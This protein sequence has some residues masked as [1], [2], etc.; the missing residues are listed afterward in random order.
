MTLNIHAEEDVQRQLALTVEVPE[1]RVQKEM[2]SVARK[3]ARTLHIPGFRKGKAPYHVMLRY[4]G[5]SSLRAEAAEEMFAAIFEEA[6]G[7]IDVTPYGQPSL[8]EMDI[9]PLVYKF[10]IPLQ[11]VVE[12]GD[13]RAIRK[14]IEPVEIT[15]EAVQQALEK[16]RERQ[17]VLE[18][19][20]RP[21][22]AG[23]MVTLAGRGTTAPDNERIFDAERTDMV[24][25][26]DQIF[27][28]QSFVDNI[29]GMEVGEEK[30]FTLNFP[31]DFED[32]ELGGAE[33]T[34]TVTVL[35][36][37]R[38]ELPDLDDDLARE[39][40]DYDS[41]EELREALAE[42]LQE[43]AEEQAKSDLFEGM[44]DDLLE[45]AEL[46]YP[47]AALTS[48]LDDM[49]AEFKQRV[50]GSG[51][52]WEDFLRLQTE[53]EETLREK[54]NEQATERLQRRLVVQQF[55]EDERLTIDKDDVS[56]AV[57]KR[58]ERYEDDEEMKSRMRD[59][60]LGQPGA[61]MLGNEILMEKISE[62]IEA[63][64]TGNAPDLDALEAAAARAIEEEE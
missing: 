60:L 11:P 27:F 42:E 20:E 17:Q 19:V 51:W 39:A 29:V 26:A 3:A 47:P 57:E 34:F 62:R 21:V 7:E 55:V 45:G 58:L 63:I 14:E 37:K 50:T 44:V 22:E 12:L 61:S 8:D 5:E 23:D 4:V 38:R 16:V 64:V 46:N 2:R 1:E 25:D 33:A 52:K 9:E 49:V 15:D 30:T 41:L 56:A 10:T 48:E 13:Y 32:E 31:D 53:T 18:P 36:I 59:W 35:E 54:W 40:G 43:Q 24:M 28:G 6:L